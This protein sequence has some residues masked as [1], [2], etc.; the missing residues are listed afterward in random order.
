VLGEPRCPEHRQ[1]EYDAR[2]THQWRF[3]VASVPP[4]KWCKTF[5]FPA[6]PR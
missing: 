4:K 6:F 5:G 3:S 1:D 2:E